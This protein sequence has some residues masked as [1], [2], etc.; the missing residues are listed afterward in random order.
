MRHLVDEIRVLDRHVLRVA[1]EDAQLAV[2]EAV[3]LRALAVV[4]ELAGELAI[5]EAVEDLGDRLGRLGEHGLERDACAV[6]EGCR[7]DR[8]TRGH[9][10]R[11]V[12]LGDAVLEQCGDDLV[13]VGQLGEDALDRIGG[14]GEHLGDRVGAAL[15]ARLV[16]LGR[17][18]GMAERDKNR[19][20][21]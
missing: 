14:L 13:V 18:G 9:L 17:R 11:L 19:G 6:S 20:L 21:G 8:R 3:D 5:L 15:L 2:V 16:V 12:Q 7:P 10:A 1:R 4:L